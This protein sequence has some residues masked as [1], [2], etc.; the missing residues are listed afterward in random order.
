MNIAELFEAN[1]VEFVGKLSAVFSRDAHAAEDAVQQA[2]LSAITSG[3]P[4][5]LSERAA[6]AWL[7]TTAKNALLDEK[8]KLSRLVLLDTDIEIPLNEPDAD[9][10]IFLKDLLEQISPELRQIVT[11]RYITGLNSAAIGQMLGIPAATVRTRLRSALKNLRK[12]LDPP[13]TL[14]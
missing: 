7:Y 4:A 10:M 5:T 6:K 8:R 1:R 11:L 12:L 2:F 13:T 14:N 3:V 9:D